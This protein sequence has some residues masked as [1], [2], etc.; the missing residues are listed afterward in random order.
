[1]RW[2]PRARCCAP[3]TSRTCRWGEGRAL[4]VG[5]HRIALFR[6]AGGWYALDDACPHRG[7]PL[8]D[9]IVADACVTCPLHERRFDLATGEGSAPGDRVAAHRVEVVGDE[10]WL[11]IAVPVLAAA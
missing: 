1:V 7:G 9:G 5:G 4:T 2:R 3:A 10:V 6:T 11:E 8:S